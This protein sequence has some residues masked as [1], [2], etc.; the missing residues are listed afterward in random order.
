MAMTAFITMQQYNKEANDTYLF[1]S[2]DETLDLAGGERMF[3]SSEMMGKEIIL[4]PGK[5]IK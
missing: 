1:K 5:E 2:K 4:A 3:M